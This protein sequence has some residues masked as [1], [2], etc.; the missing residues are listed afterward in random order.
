MP[1]YNYIDLKN[2]DVIPNDCTEFSCSYNNLTHCEN[3]PQ[4][5][6]ILICHNNI[7]STNIVLLGQYMHLFQI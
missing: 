4:S 5:L 7:H 2:K 3:L 1:C 6:E